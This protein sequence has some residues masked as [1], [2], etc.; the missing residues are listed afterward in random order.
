MDAGQTGLRLGIDTGGTF[1]DLVIGG[2]PDGLILTKRPTTPDDPLVGLL[3]VLGAGAEELGVER[4]E[5]LGRC[6]LLVFGTTR[7]T[8]AIVEGKTARTA[9][10]VTAGHPDILTLR[11]GGGRPALFDYSHEYPAP[12]VPR[13]LTFEVPERIGAGERWSPRWTRRRRSSCSRN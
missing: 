10:L 9:L 2:H 11:E 1:T 5:L 7:A 3:D 12:Y 8:N 13:R 6:D 4:R